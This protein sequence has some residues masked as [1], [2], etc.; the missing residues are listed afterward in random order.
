[1][2]L[3]LLLLL[4]FHFFPPLTLLF[5]LRLLVWGDF[6][7]RTAEFVNRGGGGTRHIVVL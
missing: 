3:P 5:P 7:G 1:M 4:L 6:C 2:S